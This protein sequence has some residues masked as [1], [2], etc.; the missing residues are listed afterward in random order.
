MLLDIRTL[1][2]VLAVSNALIFVLIGTS[3]INRRQ[4]VAGVSSWLW[5]YAA[6]TVGWSLLLLRGIVPDWLSILVGNTL[7]IIGL[8]LIFRAICDFLETPANKRISVLTVALFVFVSIAL[9][10][11]STTTTGLAAWISLV[12]GGL[13]L[14]CARVLMRNVSWHTAPARWTTGLWLGVGSSVMLLRAIAV[15][16][17]P[18]TSSYN[19]YTQSAIQIIAFVVVYSGMLGSSFGF[20]LMVQERAIHRLQ[21]IARLD[22]LTGMY[23]RR[24]LF[25]KVRHE[26]NRMQRRNSEN[27]ILMML[28]VDHFKEVNDQYGHAAGDDLLKCVAAQLAEILRAPDVLGRYGGEEFCVLLPDTNMAMGLQVAERLRIAAN[29]AKIAVADQTVQR[30]ISIGVAYACPTYLPDLSELFRTADRAL[31]QAKKEGRNRIVAADNTIP[32]AAEE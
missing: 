27:L 20:N 19:L 17:S 22:E 2:F 30:T 12:A 5:S 16:F 6:Q 29:N 18:S 15:F 23:N 32:V 31:Y 26:L 9:H 28:D 13:G 14:A 8:V 25:D 4:D 24:Y 7:L 3:F 11:S 1:L 10:V 21:Q